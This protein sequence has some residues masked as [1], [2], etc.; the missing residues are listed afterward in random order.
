[1]Y[2]PVLVLSLLVFASCASRQAVTVH[3][4]QNANSQ[5]V[6]RGGSGESLEDALVIGGI[7]K[8][9]EGLEAEYGYV[10]SKH[11]FKNKEWRL[12]G[13]TIVQEHGKIFDV[14]EI[15]LLPSSE[16][17]IYYFDVSNFPWKKK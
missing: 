7:S 10:S 9:S 16:H 14:L 2:W 5:P 13:Q 1:M 15:E 8:Q 17:R 4:Q 3:S 6:F 12:T 11:G